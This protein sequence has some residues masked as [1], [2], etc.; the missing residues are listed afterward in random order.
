M[1]KYFIASIIVFVLAA[2]VIVCGKREPELTLADLQKQYLLAGADTSGIE[3]AKVIE[4]LERYYLNLEIPPAISDSIDHDFSGL[5]KRANN[6]LLV[7]ANNIAKDQNPYALENELKNLVKNALVA[8]VKD[9]SNAFQQQMAYARKIAAGVDAGTQNSYWV[10]FVEE[11]SLFKK[12]QAEAWLKADIAQ[13]RCKAYQD[14]GS[15]FIDAERYAALG[16]K[17]LQRASDMRLR[18]DLMQRLQFILYEHRSMYE[19]SL[20]LAK[21]LLPQTDKIKYHLRLGSIVYHQAQALQRIGE[22]QAALSRYDWVIGYAK[23]FDQIAN[24]GWLTIHG[25][26]GK[27]EVAREMGEFEEVVKVSDE[28]AAQQLGT[29]E[30][31][32]LQILR[33][34]THTSKGNYEQ[35]KEILQNAISLAETAKDTFNLIVSLNNL[36]AMF[37]R[38]EEY[39]LA[40]DYYERAKSLFRAVVPDFSTRMLVLNNI[41]DIAAAKKDSVLFEKILQEAKGAGKLA[42]MPYRE[43]QF[44]RNFGSWYKKTKKYNEALPHF[45]QAI[46]ICDENGLLRF[47][48]GTRIDLVD[49][50]MGLSRFDEAKTLIM[51]IESLARQIN[52]IERI[53]DAASRYAQIQFQEH[54]VAQAIKTSNRFLHEIDVLSL[55]IKSPDLLMAYRQKVYNFL[56]SAAL[57]EIAFK[58]Q[59]SAFVKLDYAKAYALKSQLINIHA[60]NDNQPVP[61]KYLNINSIKTNLGSTSLLVDYMVIEDTLYAFVLGREK[62]QILSKTIRAETFKK[63]VTAYKDSIS[64]TIG[65]F[66]RYDAHNLD[67]HYA[68]TA[69]IG[70]NLYGYLLG[71]PELELCLQQ[72]NLLYIVPD[73]FLYEIPFSTLIGKSP[74]FPAF[75]VNRVPVVTLPSSGFL[76]VENSRRTLRKR[77]TTRVLISADRR[78]PASEKFV[79]KVKALFPVVDELMINKDS[80]T[81]DDVL[82]KLQEDYQVYIF[83][84]H[85]ATNQKYPDRGYIELSVKTRHSAT[86]KVIR[87]T[88]EDLKKLNWRDVEM[89]MLV[90]C[91][92]ASGKLYRGTGISGLNQGVLSLGTK[93]VLGNLW[94]VDASH[95]IAQAQDF[96]VSWVSAWNPSAALQA[97]QRKAIAELEANSYFRA[98]HPYFWGSYVLLTTRP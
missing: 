22:N 27:S 77:D 75:V 73:E 25:L 11:I 37:E 20:A 16:L 65:V 58:R 68:G 90:A 17:F 93:N 15:K 61:Q 32:R 52:D 76:Q 34:N 91:E 86:P 41:V 59:D 50:L 48:L 31:I 10:P 64:K 55:S 71:W 39:D 70:E 29:T 89:V 67:V 78:F 87:L 53:I 30:T 42:N 96:L 74:D 24:M 2:V 98:P 57:Y 7:N 51:A 82:S 12:E 49:C 19:L 62:L 63:T 92:T 5:L 23:K 60:N 4:R 47:A 66:Q 38:L 97:C 84:G 8:R 35:A 33:G 88:M 85:G 43:A 83:I 3:Q 69:A 40:L 44:Q 14:S 21:I 13:M 79:S 28:V 94:E 81:E 1:K 18:L 6:N 95:A 46:A 54:N 26:L 80:F 56:K 45:Q 9:E 72:T 36:G